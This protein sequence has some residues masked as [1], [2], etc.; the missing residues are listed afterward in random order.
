MRYSATADELY[1]TAGINSANAR[2]RMAHPQRQRHGKARWAAGRSRPAKDLSALCFDFVKTAVAFLPQLVAS[3][4]R[5]S[6]VS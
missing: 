5:L 2:R 3:A 6:V 4:K 1:S